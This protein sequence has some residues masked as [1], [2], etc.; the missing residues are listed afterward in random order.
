MRRK[1]EHLVIP[2]TQV[3][4]GVYIDHLEAIG[5][6]AVDRQPNTI[7]HLGDHW[8]MPSLSDWESQTKKAQSEVDYEDDIEAGLNGMEAFL[9]PIKKYNDRRKKRGL[10]LYKPRKVFCTGNH[11]QRIIRYTDQFTHLRKTIN[12]E[13]LLLKPNGWEVYDFLQPVCIDNIYYA[14][15]FYN[16][17]SGRAIGGTCLNKLNK[18]KFSF[19]MGHQQGKDVAEQYLSNGK[20]I[21]GLVVGSFYQHDE[22]YKGYQGN[23]HWQGCVYKHEVKDG[24]YDLMELSLN[25]LLSE[26]V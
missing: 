10:K 21:R 16:P 17:M 15:Y 8:D 19:T 24:N 23:S 1:N 5:N 20:T 7:I 2:D 18:L 4:K 3:K 6:Y 11:E 12:Y 13:R 25:Y 26:W 22:T 9:T 14:H